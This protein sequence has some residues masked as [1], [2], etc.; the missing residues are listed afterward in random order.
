[1]AAIATRSQGFDHGQKIRA[2]RCCSEGPPDLGEHMGGD[3]PG[4][5]FDNTKHAKTVTVRSAG[6][7]QFILRAV[8]R[9]STPK[10]QRHKPERT[11][12]FPA[13]F[14]RVS[15]NFKVEELKALIR[16]SPVLPTSNALLKGPKSEGEIAKPHVRFENVLHRPSE[17]QCEA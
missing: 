8:V 5:R 13:L 3:S 9:G 1:M 6:E 4:L 16:P 2:S 10:L 12:I 7:K 11:M 14:F 15:R 17:V